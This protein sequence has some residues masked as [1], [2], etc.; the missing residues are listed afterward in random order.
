MADKTILLVDDNEH[1][2]F[3]T[4]R[5]LQQSSIANRLVVAHDGEEA[6]DYL[7]GRGRH[8]GRNVGEMPMLTLLDL[9]M[10]RLGGLEVLQ[11]IRANSQTMYLPVVILTA[12]RE[13]RDKLA[14]YANGCNA[15]VTKPVD[16]AQFAEAV[17]QLG[18]F[19]LV[20]N[21]PPPNS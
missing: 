17:R 4:R 14:S 20:H 12:S 9:K 15:Y 16:F 21:E 3:L 8:A 11:H 5:A 18:L 13:E 2:V 10:P 6:L 7:M 19:W 1:D